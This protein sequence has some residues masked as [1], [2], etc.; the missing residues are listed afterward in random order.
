KKK[1]KSIKISTNVMCSKKSYQVWNF[2]IKNAKT[3]DWVKIGDNQKAE[4]W[5]W[6]LL[7]FTLTETSSANYVNYFDAKHTLKLRMSTPATKY[8]ENIQVDYLTLILEIE[9]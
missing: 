5:K 4:D 1:I 6:S 9:N 8:P 7:N 2:D 3:S